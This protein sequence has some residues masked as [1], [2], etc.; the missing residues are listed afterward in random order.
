MVL[1]SKTPLDYLDPKTERIA[2]RQGTV[3]YS[4]PQEIRVKLSESK[5]RLPAH[6]KWRLDPYV[7][8]INRQRMLEA[9]EALNYNPAEMDDKSSHTEEYELYGTY[10]RDI[11]LDDWCNDSQSRPHNPNTESTDIIQPPQSG[12][13]ISDERIRDWVRRHSLPTPKDKDD[14]PKLSLN[15]SQ[16]H[17]IAQMIG[18]RFSLVQ[19]VSPVS[20]C[21]FQLF[22]TDSSPL[23]RGKLAP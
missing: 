18:E 20:K 2:T 21:I 23:V 1:S 8:D 14:D 22:D 5:G 15:T 4:S 13:F 16:I 3:V 19:G 6:L 7:S 10:L 11:I 9:I 12:L 17:A